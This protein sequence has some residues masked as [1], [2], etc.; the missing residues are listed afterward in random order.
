MDAQ[1]HQEL[2]RLER[3]EAEYRVTLS[4]LAVVTER[5]QQC[6]RSAAIEIAPS[7]LEDSP[8]LIASRDPRTGVVAI[9]AER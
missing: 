2:S 5:L 8:D 7:A 4:T 1:L 3:I 6:T 9:R